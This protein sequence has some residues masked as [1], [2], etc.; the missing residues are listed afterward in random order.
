MISR[1]SLEG[2]LPLAKTLVRRGISLEAIEDTPVDVL[3]ETTTV[4]QNEDENSGEVINTEATAKLTSSTSG[5]LPT[6]HNFEFDLL[7]EDGKEK[8]QRELNIARNRVVPVVEKLV[9]EVQKQLESDVGNGISKYSIAVENISN[10]YRNGDFLT[11]VEEFKDSQLKPIGSIIPLGESN[12]AQ[13]LE[14]VKTGFK[15]IDEDIAVWIA[16]K[17][18]GYLTEVWNNFF[19]QTPDSD[20]RDFNVKINEDKDIALAVFLLARNL[21][22]NPPEGT[23]MDLGTYNDKLSALRNMAGYSLYNQLGLLDATIQAGVLVNCV[24]DHVAYLNN[25]VYEQFVRDGG[26]VDTILGFVL[27]SE[28]SGISPNV[29]TLAYIQENK[30]RLLEAWYHYTSLAKATASENKYRNVRSVLVSSF[31]RYIEGEKPEDLNREPSLIY[32]DFKAA[33]QRVGDEE[34]RDI[35]AAVLKVVCQSWFK[36]TD[37]YFILSRIDHHTKE[38]PGLRTREAATLATIDYVTDWVFKQIRINAK[39]V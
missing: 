9:E 17:G 18:E 38:N 23:G 30:E 6:P 24:K 22:D 21:F 20:L 39:V 34:L 27:L 13:L 26:D 4:V 36:D 15:G 8:V 14:L 12:P 29:T 19:N 31:L 10:I 33:L 5:P 2:I 25:D 37:A 3:T 1:K 16:E 28:N 7:L 11:I 35:H 32:N